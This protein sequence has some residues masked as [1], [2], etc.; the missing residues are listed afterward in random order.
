MGAAGGGVGA[1]TGVLYGDRNGEPRGAGAKPDDREPAP[2]SLRM[3]GLLSP[4]EERA[5]TG[6]SLLASGCVP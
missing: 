6:E 3:T 1:L 4:I 5:K 2:R